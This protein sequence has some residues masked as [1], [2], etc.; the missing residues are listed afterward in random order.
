MTTHRISI[1]FQTAIVFF[2]LKN[3]NFE[4]VVYLLPVENSGHKSQDI[5]T[6]LKDFKFR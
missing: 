3:R 1:L 4:K 5:N 6:V 2:Y